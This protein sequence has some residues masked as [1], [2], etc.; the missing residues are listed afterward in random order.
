MSTP[1]RVAPF[2]IQP[3]P[4]LLERHPYLRRAGNELARAYAGGHFVS[5]QGL[6]AVGQQ[7]WQVLAVDSAFAQARRRAGAQTLPV[8]IASNDAAIQ[9]LPWETLHHPEHGFLGLANGFTLLRNNGGTLPTPPAVDQGP[10]RVLLFTTLP[11]DLDAEKSRL[12]VEE[13]QAQV[14]EA[15]NPWIAEGVVKLEVPDDGRF[16]T[17]QTL[18]RQF[19]PHLLFLS[20]HGKFHHEP[21]RAEAP[22]ASFLFEGE[23]GDGHSVRDKEIADALLGSDVGCVVLSACESGMTASDSLTNGLTWRLSQI[24][25]PHMI[26]M[27]ESVLD[28][29]GTL[30]VRAFCDAV[31]RRQPIDVALQEGRRAITTPLKE[32]LWLA[33]D[34]SGL[35]ERSLGQWPLPSLISHDPAQPLIDWNFV[36]QPLQRQLNQSL[37]TVSLPPRFIGRRSELRSLQS[38][39]R[40]GQLRQ[41]LISGPGGQGKTALAGK[42]RNCSNGVISSFLPGRLARAMTGSSSRLI[43]KLP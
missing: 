13:E 32:S 35:A 36:P 43:W 18:L 37:N 41:L 38:R 34:A 40:Q 14:L 5:D 27:R 16:A 3:D 33:D 10:L 15:L 25:I 30:F 19:R 6:Q 17:L 26:G 12:D 8:I 4:A 24:G 39:L 20:G 21:H 7:L 2:V 11:D 29:A 22:Y 31:V 42:R 28:R 9:Q 1:Q 23:D